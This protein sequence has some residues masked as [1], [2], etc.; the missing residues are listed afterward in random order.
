VSDQLD[1]DL[2]RAWRLAFGVET[3]EG[4]VE[5][6]SLLPTL[7][8]AGYVATDGRAWSFTVRGIT[9]VNELAPD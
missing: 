5:L 3:D 1:A 9:R 7:I 8:G 2:L 4:W 6:E